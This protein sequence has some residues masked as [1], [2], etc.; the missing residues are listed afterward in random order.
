[1]DTQNSKSTYEL[2]PNT[3]I[4]DRTI[5]ILQF[6]YI[7]VGIVLLIILIVQY[8]QGKNNFI[9]ILTFSYSVSLVYFGYK[10]TIYKINK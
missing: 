3:K 2:L 8:I 5:F 6:Y 4:S 9:S 10:N 7:L 1:M